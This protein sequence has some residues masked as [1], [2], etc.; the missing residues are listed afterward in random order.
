MKPLNVVE[1]PVSSVA[2]NIRRK[3]ARRWICR[4]HP[5]PRFRHHIWPVKQSAEGLRELQHDEVILGDFIQGLDVVADAS[6]MHRRAQIIFNRIKRLADEGIVR[7]HDPAM[8]RSIP[9]HAGSGVANNFAAGLL[10]GAAHIRTTNF[11]LRESA[12]D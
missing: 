11:R 3:C 7:Q 6:C 10:P 8:F 2:A 5:F 9:S 12:G 1:F 4:C